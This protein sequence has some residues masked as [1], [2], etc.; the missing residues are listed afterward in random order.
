[1]LDGHGEDLPPGFHHGPL[2]GRRERNAA[3]A[4]AH[5][6]PGFLSP[7]KVAGHLNGQGGRFTRGQVQRV[8]GPVPLIEE[9]GGIEGQ[10]LDVRASKTSDLGY[11]LRGHVITPHVHGRVP[12]GQEVDGVPDPLGLDV[13]RL[14]IG[15]EHLALVVGVEDAEGRILPSPVHPPLFVPTPHPIHREGGS[16]WRKGDIGGPLGGHHD[17]RSPLAADRPDPVEAHG[18]S[19]PGGGVKDARTIPGPTTD[20]GGGRVKG[21]ALRRAAIDANDVHAG[22][23]VAVGR[24][25]DGPAIRGQVGVAFH[26]S[27]AGDAPG[28]PTV[29][30]C[31]PDIGSVDKDDV[32]VIHVGLF[33]QQRAGILPEQKGGCEGEKKGRCESHGAARWQQA[34]CHHNG[35]L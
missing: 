30:P 15:Q 2:S 26:R 6:F 14:L 29:H 25:G 11:V 21:Q 10:V 18:G 17:F 27:R 33:Q 31:N 16:V 24:E 32:I 13:R 34:S 35:G 28:I 20:H 3:D 22:G 5:V 23:A 7:R 1:M 19:F 12:V 9:V 8:E 4:L